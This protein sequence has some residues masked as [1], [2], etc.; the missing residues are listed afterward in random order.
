MRVFI[1]FLAFVC[2]SAFAD[3]VEYSYCKTVRESIVRPA[4]QHLGI[5]DPVLEDLLV[6]TAAVE[7]ASGRYNKQIGGVALGMFQVEKETFYDLRDRG[8]LLPLLNELDVPY[9][10]FK[11]DHFYTAGVALSYYVWKA[12]RYELPEHNYQTQ[13]EYMEYL[14]EL[15]GYWKVHY[16]S[17]LGKGS[18]TGFVSAYFRDGCYLSGNSWG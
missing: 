6:G 13:E 15:A 17:Y 1:L 14:Y 18:K 12:E 3:P 7:S 10:V 5:N 2:G 4:M 9:R 8:L 11:G 16:N